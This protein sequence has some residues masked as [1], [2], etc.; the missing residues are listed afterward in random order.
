[1]MTGRPRT[2][3]TGPNPPSF[4]SGASAAVFFRD[5]P[6]RLALVL[7]LVLRVLGVAQIGVQLLLNVWSGAVFDAIEQRDTTELMRQVAVFAGLAV[8]FLALSAYHLYGKMRFQ[9]EWRIWIT[10]HLVADW[11]AHGRHREL[12]R[13]GQSHD[14]PD[15]RIAED[16]RPRDEAAV[17]FADGS[18]MRC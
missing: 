1:M 12:S 7:V 13:M 8:A 16:V 9:V 6:R 5:R 4:A 15:Q 17:D 3:K 18:F 14:N 2:K 11:L 10:D